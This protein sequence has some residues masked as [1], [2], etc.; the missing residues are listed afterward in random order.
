M[1]T[2]E[3]IKFLRKQ[4]GLSQKEL[5]EVLG[6]K[7]SSVQKYESGA[8][9]NLK[10]QTIKILCEYFKIQPWLLIYPEKVDITQIP[11]F[12]L[13]ELTDLYLQLNEQGLKKVLEYTKDLI[14]SKNYTGEKL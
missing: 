12:Q 11:R 3:I 4:E 6:V 5:A 8:V 13:I 1:H 14:D 9:L 2:G 10:M 7:L